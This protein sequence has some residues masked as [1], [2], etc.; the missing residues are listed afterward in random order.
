MSSEK[1]PDIVFEDNEDE[2][3]EIIV[4][5]SRDNIPKEKTEDDELPE[6]YKGKSKKE[7]VELLNQTKNQADTVNAL[8]Q[9]I[10]QLGDKIRPQYAQPQVQQPQGKS[11]DEFFKDL[12]T[13]AFKEGQ[14]AK[15]IK[16]AIRR[17][18][19]PVQGFVTN[20]IAALTKKNIGSDPI[21][22]KYGNEVEEFIN[23]TIP[24]YRG[25][26]QGYEFALKEIRA[27]H[28]E[29][30]IKDE[31]EKRISESLKSNNQK[32]KNSIPSFSERSSAPAAGLKQK[33][34]KIYLTPKEETAYKKYAEERGIPEEKIR[35][36]IEELRTKKII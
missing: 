18:L 4:I 30:I 12:E 29:D 36:R 33:T 2:K 17:E 10:A 31:V 7:L 24:Q 11:D 23:T 32:E 19:N 14:F 16:E 21:Y 26:P 1:I 15:T 13:E 35:E 9:G 27:R 20:Q 34:N 6:D 5:D 8:Q 28:M 22:Q 3:D 25:T